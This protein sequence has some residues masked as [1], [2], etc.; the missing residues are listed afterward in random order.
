MPHRANKIPSDNTVEELIAS[1]END[2]RYS[3]ILEK[4]PKQYNKGGVI[5][6][7]AQDFGIL[8]I[9]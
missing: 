8:L 1:V 9:L 3:K 4:E 6:I 7:G 5:K 2:E